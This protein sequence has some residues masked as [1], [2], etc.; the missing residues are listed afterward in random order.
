MSIYSA[1]KLSETYENTYLLFFVILLP[2]SK[3]QKILILEN[4]DFLREII[5]TQLHKKGGYLLTAFSIAEGIEQAKD[6]HIDT[7]I[8]GTSCPEYKGKETLAYINKQLEQND[9]NF[10]I[11]NHENKDL[12]FVDSSHQMRCEELS[13]RDIVN[14][15]PV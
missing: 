13:I 14:A 2:M 9:I 6:H 12:D 1:S 11:I 8:L 3:R 7:I 15:I 10:F 4:D 5:G